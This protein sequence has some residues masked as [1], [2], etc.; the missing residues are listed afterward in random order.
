MSTHADH[1]I[2]AYRQ[3]H[4]AIYGYPVRDLRRL[5]D[6]RILLHGALLTPDELDQLTALLQRERV[7]ASAP[8]PSPLRRLW[9]WLNQ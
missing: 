6:G 2:A 5:P 9:N 3:A 7:Q 4:A 8:A 1:A